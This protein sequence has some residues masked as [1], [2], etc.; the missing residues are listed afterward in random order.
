MSSSATG[1]DGGSD[2]ICVTNSIILVHPGPVVEHNGEVDSYYNL[3]CASSSG[4]SSI[5]SDN[6]AIRRK[7]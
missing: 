7:M 4:I 2:E 5:R 6:E 3:S 1:Q